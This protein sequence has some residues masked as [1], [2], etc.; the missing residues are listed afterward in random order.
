MQDKKVTEIDGPRR[1]V[2]FRLNDCRRGQSRRIEELSNRSAEKRDPFDELLFRDLL[3]QSGYVSHARQGV[4][5][6]APAKAI[7]IRRG[8]WGQ[9]LKLKVSSS[10]RLLQS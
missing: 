2:P 10:K 3:S 9:A 7:Q 8:R 4:G 1:E 5:P 6:Q